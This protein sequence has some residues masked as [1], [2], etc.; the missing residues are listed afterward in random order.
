MV[1]AIKMLHPKLRNARRLKAEAPSLVNTHCGNTHCALWQQQNAV[2]ECVTVWIM[3]HCRLAWAKSY[4]SDPTVCFKKIDAVTFAPFGV[5][6]WKLDYFWHSSSLELHNSVQTP[7]HIDN[8]DSDG[9]HGFEL[10]SHQYHRIFWPLQS[11]AAA[12]L[13]RRALHADT[14]KWDVSWAWPAQK[15]VRM[16]LTRTRVYVFET[17]CSS[18]PFILAS[19]LSWI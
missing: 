1:L 19:Q 18:T 6:S 2:E 13:P 11:R 7:T 17:D 14:F 3:L 16:L 10:A 8:P 5:M 12:C 9:F 4:P 15:H